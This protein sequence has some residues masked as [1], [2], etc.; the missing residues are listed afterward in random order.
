MIKSGIIGAVLGIAVVVPAYGQ[1]ESGTDVIERAMNI[2]TDSDSGGKFKTQRIKGE[3]TGT[4]L[5]LSNGGDIYIGDFREK[6]FQ[7]R[8]MYI[9][10][11]NNSVENCPDARIYVGHFKNGVK[12]GKGVCYNARGE[13]IYDGRFEADKPVDVYPQQ[14]ETPVYAGDLQTDEFYYI[15]EMEGGAPSGYGAIFLPTG[16]FAVSRFKDGQ[17]RGNTVY[18]YDDGNWMCE[19]VGSDGTITPISSSLEYAQFENEREESYNETVRAGKEYADN[20]IAEMN[21][22]R[23]SA[24]TISSKFLNV[25][26]IV[27]EAFMAAG[28]AVD[29]YQQARTSFSTSSDDYTGSSAQKSTKEGK[30]SSNGFSLSEQQSYN[31]DKSTYNRYESMISQALAGNREAKPSEIVDWQNK[32]RQLR[33]KWEKK[34]KSF[35]HSPHEN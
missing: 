1:I 15:G 24:P 29:Q 4:G 28:N 30:S 3:T 13:M 22:R 7:G 17:R 8:G 11:E 18:V 20:S 21:K 5:Y 32:M 16:D 23:K 27:G 25:L 33:I 12:E 31:R 10:T 34:G 26:M 2:A 35:P 6:K 19:K 14:M 9:G